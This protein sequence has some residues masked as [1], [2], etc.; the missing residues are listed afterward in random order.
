MDSDSEG[1]PGYAKDPK[2]KKKA[3]GD[4]PCWCVGLIY[5]GVLLGVA[6]IV[7]ALLFVFD[8]RYNFITF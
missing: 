4:L 7:V 8:G 2:R 6:I 3:C 5:L 1:L